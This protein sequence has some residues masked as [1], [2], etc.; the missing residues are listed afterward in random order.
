MYEDKTLN[1]AECSEEFVFSASEQEFYAEKGFQNEPKRCPSCRSARKKERR[2]TRQMHDVVCDGCG[3]T[4]QVP[5][6]PRGDRPVYCDECFKANQ[7]R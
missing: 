5:F 6:L 1:C 2:S 3:K 4:A 7:N